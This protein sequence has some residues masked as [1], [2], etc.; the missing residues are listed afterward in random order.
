MAIAPG[1]R[2]GPYEFR[3]ALGAGGMGEVW[4]ARDARL[5]RDVAVKVL[6]GHLLT[7]ADRLMRFRREARAASAFNHPHVCTV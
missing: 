3:S 6:P 1:T 7:D 2:V 4:R 5:E